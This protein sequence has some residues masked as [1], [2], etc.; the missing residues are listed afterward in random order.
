VLA[1]A[2]DETAPGGRFGGSAAMWD[3]LWNIGGY[4]LNYTGRLERQQWIVVFTICLVVGFFFTRGF[5]SR[6]NY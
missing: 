5:G 6:S 1:A 4:A 2:A 3:Y